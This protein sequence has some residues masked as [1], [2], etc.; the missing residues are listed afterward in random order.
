[1]EKQNKKIVT[2]SFVLVGFVTYYVVNVLFQSFASSIGVIGKYWSIVQ[3]QHGLPVGL[4]I[5]MFILLQFNAKVRFWGNEVVVEIRKIV[6]PSRKD[7][8]AMTIVSCVMLLVSAAV[9]GLFDA[10]STEL[11][12]FI[13]EL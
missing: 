9:L 5:L 10:V 4:G 3:I 2:F 13:L 7:T 1:M 6:W 11:V 12:K 8:M